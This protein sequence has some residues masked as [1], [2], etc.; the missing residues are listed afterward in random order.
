MLL[1]SAQLRY[2][3]KHVGNNTKY[4]ENSDAKGCLALPRLA[5]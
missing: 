2:R 3:G 4:S 5:T 1:R